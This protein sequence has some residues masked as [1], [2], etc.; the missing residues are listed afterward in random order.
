MTRSTLFSAIFRA[1]L[2]VV[3]A[4]FVCFALTPRADAAED[5]SDSMRDRW[6]YLSYNLNDDQGADW[7]V[8]II[9]RAGKVQLNGMLWASQWDRADEWNDAELARFHKIKSAAEKADVEIIPILWSI[10]YGTMIGRDP[11]LAEGARAVTTLVA[12]NGRAV[13]EE[14]RVVIPNGD[15]EEWDG[16]QLLS[17]NGGFQDRPNVVSFRDQKNARNGKSALK[18]ENYGDDKNGHGRVMWRLDLQPEGVYQASVWMKGKD[19]KGRALLQAYSSNG[20]QLSASPVPFKNDKEAQTFD[21]QEI[22]VNFRVPKDGKILLYAGVWDGTEGALWLDDITLKRNGFTNP[23][24][25][26]GAP[27]RVF[28]EDRQKEYEQGKDWSL[29]DFKIRPHQKD[30][31]SQSLILPEGSAIRENE[32]LRVEYYFPIIIGSSQVSACMSE[33][34]IYEYFKKS[35][36]AVV[37]LL[38]PQKWFLSMDEIRCAGTCEA[39][40]AR[41]ISLAEILGDCIT[42]QYEIIKERSPNASVYIWSDMID[43]NHNCHDNYYSCEGDYSGAWKFVPK[44]IIVSCWWYDMR[45]KSMEFFSSQGFKTQ[46]AAYYDTDDLEG[47]KDWLVTCKKTPGCVGIM[48]TTWQKKYDLMEGFGEL[49]QPKE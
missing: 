37:K 23:L 48:Y 1:A 32:R 35:A 47:C 31:E 39:C 7:V 11:N 20:A 15:M 21:W 33:P 42:R 22:K 25:R 5:A 2:V 46:G 13:Y 45:E 4:V 36:D 38:N 40:H 6:F 41:G 49:V 30:V 12:R 10:G 9:E 18:F 27:I 28:S 17:L 44:E 14:E 3:A 43:P 8:S 16:A 34:E 29:P 26:A 19:F 24:R